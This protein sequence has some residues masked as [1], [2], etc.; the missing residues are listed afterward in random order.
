V[1]K[2]FRWTDLTRAM[3]PHMA[4]EGKSSADG[5]AE[6]L[7]VA[8][9]SAWD[10]LNEEVG[11]EA[12]QAITSV[13]LR[14]SRSRLV[15]LAE[16]AASGDMKGIGREAHA[17]KGSVDM[18]GFERMTLIASMLEI[19]G[20]ETNELDACRDLLRDLAEAFVEVEALCVE[21]VGKAF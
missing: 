9:P 6:D 4:M 2:P 18:L 16:H 14:D 10:K 3:A 20:K 5:T 17:L 15:R 19:A 21:R 12:A 7:L 1:T 11:A 8:N 13:F